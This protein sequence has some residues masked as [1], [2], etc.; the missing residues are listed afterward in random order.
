MKSLAQSLDEW[1][2]RRLRMCIW[3]QWKK[4][5]T[6]F[7]N[8]MKLGLDREKAWEFAG[9]SSLLCSMKNTTAVERNRVT[10]NRLTPFC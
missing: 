5:R 9:N 10:P 7:Q 8:L 6:R 4:V 3:K 1:T 2:R